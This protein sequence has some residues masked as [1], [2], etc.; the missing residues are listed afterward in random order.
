MIQR[1]KR[2]EIAVKVSR[3]GTR[4]VVEKGI[5]RFLISAGG[6]GKV[7]QK[8]QLGNGFGNTST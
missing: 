3:E 7:D 4:T 8:D 6:W 5:Q 1:Q 2:E